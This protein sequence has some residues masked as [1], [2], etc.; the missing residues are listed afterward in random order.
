MG[1]RSSVRGD[2][3]HVKTVVGLKGFEVGKS[4]PATASLS[5]L[6]MSFF[7]SAKNRAAS[8][9]GCGYNGIRCLKFRVKTRMGLERFEVAKS[10]F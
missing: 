7:K 9:L 8:S 10:R 3:V 4:R 2:F 6:T 1:R 5:D